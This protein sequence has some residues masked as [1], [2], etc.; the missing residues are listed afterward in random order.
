MSEQEKMLQP[1]DKVSGRGNIREGR[2]VG[3]RRRTNSSRRR[4][5]TR[6]TGQ[7]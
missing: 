6:T 4:L 1:A 5:Q 2:G 3:K 7:F